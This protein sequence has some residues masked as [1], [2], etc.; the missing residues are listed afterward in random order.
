MSVGS[1]TVRIDRWLWAVRLFKTRSLAAAACRAGRVSV[2]EGEAKPSRLLRVGCELKIEGGDLV[3]HVRVIALLEKRVGAKLVSDYME[4]LTTEEAKAQ[5]AE[6]REQRKAG[7]PQLSEG[8]PTKRQ[9]RQL[10]DFL[11]QVE[12]TRGK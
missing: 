1:E 7:A 6:K 8:R 11:D 10:Q 9:R 5:A 12:R 2:D 4:D 3:R